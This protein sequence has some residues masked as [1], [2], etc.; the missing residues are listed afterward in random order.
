MGGWL[1]SEQASRT[2]LG[3]KQ[4]RNF[5]VHAAGSYLSQPAKACVMDAIVTTQVSDQEKLDHVQVAY[6]GSLSALRWMLLAGT[7]GRT[8]E[9]L[10]I[11]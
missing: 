2:N 3:W 1:L 7:Q 5:H 4:F 11:I 10:L 6:S 9:W 8:D